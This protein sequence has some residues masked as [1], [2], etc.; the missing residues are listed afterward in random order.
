MLPHARKA[1]QHAPTR[2][3]FMLFFEGRITRYLLVAGLA[4]R[5]A[6]A[7]SFVESVP[8]PTPPTAYA[9]GTHDCGSMALYLDENVASVPITGRLTH[10]RVRGVPL[11]RVALHESPTDNTPSISRDVG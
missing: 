8:A 7:P 9:R 5:K 2:T 1:G 4:P 6:I 3:D 11:P 10:P